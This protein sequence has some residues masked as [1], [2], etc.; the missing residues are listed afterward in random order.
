[1]RKILAMLLLAAPAASPAQSIFGS[2]WAGDREV[3][4]TWG[5]G[6]N[7]FT[8][9]QDYELTRLDFVLPGVVV[10]DPSLLDVSNDVWHADVK[11]DV[12][13]LPFLNV[14]VVAGYIDGDTAVDISALQLPL[15]FTEF[16]VDYDGESYGGGATLAFGGE[17]WF[18]SLTGVY[19]ET[20]L[21][22]D[23]D[24]SV[25]AVTLQPRLGLVRG[26]WQH[27]LGAMYLDA[28]ERH[29]GT[30]A[31]PFVGDV[32]FDIELREKDQWNFAIGTR[33]EFSKKFEASL[34]I[35]VGDRQT[36]LLY[37]GYRF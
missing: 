22:G 34:E 23:F 10:E 33:Y 29:R 4:L 35:G 5:V 8:M 15:P 11:F 1:M 37:A 20:S 19:T 16:M 24:S 12:W 28:E 13:L 2:E 14:F 30:I 31:L 18:G 25:E 36:T 26:Q 3:P 9:F 7:F 17:G 32:P 6:A 27:W 21:S